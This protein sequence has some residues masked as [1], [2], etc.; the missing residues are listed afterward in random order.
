MLLPSPA[1]AAGDT[2][3]D[4]LGLLGDYGIEY[5]I[6]VAHLYRGDQSYALGVLSAVDER[7]RISFRYYGSGSPFEYETIRFLYVRKAL[8]ED[9]ALHAKG[10]HKA[11]DVSSP[12]GK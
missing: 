8:I 5:G 2:L 11:R 10:P 9:E 6:D 4:S 3:R 12:A 7:S 1:V